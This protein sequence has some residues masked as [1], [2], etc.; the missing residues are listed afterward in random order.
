METELQTVI[1]RVHDYLLGKRK[2]KGM[3]MIVWTKLTKD[4]WVTSKDWVNW[5][6]RATRKRLNVG[7]ASSWEV[8]F[9]PQIY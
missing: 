8:H 4:V 9:G 1:D 2:N 3:S 7:K 5:H 6:L